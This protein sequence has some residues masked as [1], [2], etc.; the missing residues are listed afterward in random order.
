MEYDQCQ[1]CYGYCCNA[2]NITKLMDGEVERIAAYLDIPE[3][4]FRERFITNLY[5]HVG[6]SKTDWIKKAN[7]C[8]FWAAGRCSIHEVKPLTCAV[9]EPKD[10]QEHCK[11]FHL[12]MWGT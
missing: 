6:E 12:S 5:T 7:P 2:Y 8:P 9:Y 11:Q 10:T 3:N 4:D 1:N